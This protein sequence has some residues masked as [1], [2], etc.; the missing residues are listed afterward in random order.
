M[1]VK[2]LTLQNLSPSPD[3]SHECLRSY[4]SSPIKA[5]RSLGDTQPSLSSCKTSRITNQPI[6]FGRDDDPT[7]GHHIQ[8][9]S[10][11]K[12]SSLSY[13]RRHLACTKRDTR[14]RSWRLSCN[15]MTSLYTYH[16]TKHISRDST[17]CGGGLNRPAGINKSSP[18]PLFL[19]FSFF[20]S[21]LCL[22]A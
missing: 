11:E 20:F 17:P 10:R 9:L 2:A 22:L 1:L 14:V 19:F 15:S 21:S 7:T 16:M 12:S 6:I 5:W 13:L 18:L 8:S 3:L 4:Y